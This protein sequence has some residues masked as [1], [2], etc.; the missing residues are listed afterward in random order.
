MGT[1]EEAGSRMKRPHPTKIPWPAVKSC[2][3]TATRWQQ[4][5]DPAAG[6]GKGR[7]A[8]AVCLT[9]DVSL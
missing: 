1:L 8:P 2:V 3:P 7:A 4:S 5:S 6:L 9:L